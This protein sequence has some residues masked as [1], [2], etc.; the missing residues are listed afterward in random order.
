MSIHGLLSR[1]LPR[2]IRT[3]IIIFGIRVKT[4]RNRITGSLFLMDRHGNMMSRQRNITCT[5]F[6]VNNRISTGKTLMCEPNYMT[7]LTGGLIKELTVSASMLFHILK[8][9]PDFLI[10]QILRISNMYL[11]LT[12]I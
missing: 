6:P 1:V 2:I 3:E 9:F 11:P 10:C 5:Y 12:D 4:D 7:W 8:K